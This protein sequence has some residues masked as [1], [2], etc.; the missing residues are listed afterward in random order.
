MP[1][2]HK[3]DLSPTFTTGFIP[4]L[5]TIQRPTDPC[6]GLKGFE[7]QR[8]EANQAKPPSGPCVCPVREKNIPAQ[9]ICC[10]ASSVHNIFKIQPFLFSRTVL[11]ALE[12]VAVRLISLQGV[13]EKAQQS[14]ISDKHSTQPQIAVKG[15]K[16]STRLGVFCQLAQMHQTY[17]EG[18][19]RSIHI[20]NCC[21]PALQGGKQKDASKCRASRDRGFSSAVSPD[22]WLPL[23]TEPR[24]CVVKQTCSDPSHPYERTNVINQVTGPHP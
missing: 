5:I 11:S 23:K 18:L 19:W 3:V 10:F 6:N 15:P 4:C 21:L 16:S 22:H 20:P 24:D 14:T 7:R 1:E 12:V 9:D 2:L 8:E 17:L 13:H